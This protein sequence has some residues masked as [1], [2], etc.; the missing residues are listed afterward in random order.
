M[1]EPKVEFTVNAPANI[2]AERTVREVF[3]L[4]NYVFFDLGSTKIPP[5]Y[6]TL[7]KDQVKDFKED[8]V[9]LNTP[10]NIRVVTQAAK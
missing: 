10:E 5:R 9:Q 6:V 4:R 8:Q 3:P 1:V 2:P 7:R